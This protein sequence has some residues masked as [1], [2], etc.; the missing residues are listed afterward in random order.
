MSDDT[1]IRD[2]PTGRPQ[3]PSDGQADPGVLRQ[4]AALGAVAAVIRLVWVAVMSREPQGLSDLTLYPLFA[5]GIADGAGYVSLGG[6]PTAYYPPGYPFFL[7]GIQWVLD[8]VGLGEHLVLVAGLVQ[9]VLGGIAVGAVVVI[10]HRVVGGARGRL[11]GVVAG[12]TLLLWPNLV[13]H[14]SLM[15]SETLFIA[16]FVVML[17]ALVLSEADE[18]DVPPLLLAAAVLSGLC[19]LVRPQS[20]VLTIPA[21][22]LAW[23]LGRPD[24]RRLLLRAGVLVL[25]TVLIVAPWSI[26][27]AV[28]FDG[29][30]PV[31]TNTGDNLCM[32]FNPDATGGF[33]FAEACETGEFYVDGPEQEL[34]RDAE[35]RSRAIDWA[36]SNLGA[37]PALSWT[38]VQLTYRDDRDALAALES[39]GEDQFLSSSTRTV[40]G[41]ISDVYFFGVLSLAV[42]GGVVAVLRGWR[43]RARSTAPLLVVFVTLAGAVVPVLSFAD[44]R[45]KVPLAPCFAVLAAVA[46]CAA[47]DRWRPS[48]EP[49]V[50]T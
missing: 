41:G 32:G 28:V 11:A 27:N 30:V 6:H 43:G 9:A 19:T 20:A 35:A 8:R 7:G 4:A 12:G 46:V 31:S 33:M 13:Q 18:R 26:R 42:V 39:F 36:T 44:T 21:V 50:A 48:E 23:A 47:V 15:L 45:F 34:R 40:L 22:V 3:L 38:K 14:S 16:L 1:Q 29:F 2:A 24:L 25:G 49:E 37:L 17:A 10:A 5:R